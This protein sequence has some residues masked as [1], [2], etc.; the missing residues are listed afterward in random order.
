MSIAAGTRVVEVVEVSPRDGLQ[1]E[2]VVVSTAIKVELV[3]RAVAAGVR[4]IEV[5]SF[6]DPERVPQ[7]AD[8]EAVLAALSGRDDVT[9][10]GLVLNRRGFERARAAGV[11]EVN[12]VVACTDSFAEHNQGTSVE[13]TLAR[14][15]DIAATAHAAGVR[16][17]A[18]L[19]VAFGC[20]YE[21][22]VPLPRVAALA[23]RCAEAGAVEIAIADTIGVAVPTDVSERLAALSDAA[24]GVARRAH[25]HNTRN[26][27]LANAWAAVLG[28]VD[29]LDASIGGIG[30]CPFA[31]GATGNIATEDLAYL[32]ARAGIVTGLDL[33]ALAEI[34]SWIETWLGHPMA[35]QLS[36]AGLFPPRPTVG[37]GGGRRPAKG[38][39]PDR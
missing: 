9:Y 26:T 11:R 18:T 32:L 35:G 6:V 4:R 19:S 37:D 38:V 2:A 25:F 24:P 39:P 8:A 10:V 34:P 15:A 23:R 3:G 13:G 29:A 28:G 17:T 31:P 5:A 22:E 1:A 14:F 12:A 21:G 27:G 30:G 36:K 16:P 7:M 33:A 20:P